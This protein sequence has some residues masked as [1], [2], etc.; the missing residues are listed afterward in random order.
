MFLYKK[1]KFFDPETGKE[2][3][4]VLKRSG[5]LSDLTG[6]PIDLDNDEEKPLYT[7]SFDY[8]HGSEP[9]WYEDFYDLLRELKLSEENM[10]YSDFSQFM[11]SPYHFTNVEGYGC[12]DETESIMDQW[13]TDRKKKGVRGDV[14]FRGCGTIEQVLSKIR[15]K[16]LR[17]LIE[18]K[19]YTLE[20]LGFVQENEAR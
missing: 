7:L 2:V 13:I 1:K 15:V 16:T 10:E 11:E 20:Q 5:Y 17:R 14:E 4:P 8:D 3:E 12:T 19:V 6:K 9:L 18:E